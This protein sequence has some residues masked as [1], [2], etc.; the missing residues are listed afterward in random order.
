MP[1]L[2]KAEARE[3]EQQAE[4]SAQRFDP[5]PAGMYI[6][7]LTEVVVSDK[8]GDSGYE[9]WMWRWDLEDDGYSGKTAQS[10]TSLSP[11]AAFSFGLH[12][13]AFGVPADTHTDE[14]VGRLALL[15]LS[16]VPSSK[17]PN[18][19]VNRVEEVLPFDGESGDGSGAS[20]ED[21]G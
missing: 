3:A 6:G 7:K 19:M 17:D 10:I 12:F 13:K 9:Y 16:Q 18:R 21:F 8:A 11:K 1:Q 5:V 4:E 20:L 2:S 14:L 15:N